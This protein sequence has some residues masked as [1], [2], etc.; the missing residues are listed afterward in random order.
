MKVKNLIIE[1]GKFIGWVELQSGTTYVWIS[2]IE[3][4]E[5]EFSQNTA[6]KAKE[7]EYTKEM[8]KDME[9]SSTIW[10]IRGWT[11]SYKKETDSKKKMGCRKEYF[12]KKVVK[13]TTKSQRY[14]WQKF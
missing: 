1:L 13:F 6:Q 3:D 11:L 7:M 4:Q 10:I 2:E 14:W 12:I 8:L 5:E 9:D